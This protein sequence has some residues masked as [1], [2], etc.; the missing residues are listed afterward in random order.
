MVERPMPQDVMKFKA[1][2][3]GN[4][5]AR[6]VVWGMLGVAA[7][8]GCFFGFGDKIGANT[9]QMK[10]I[11]CAIPSIPFFLIGFMPIMGMPMEK[12]LIPIIVDNFIAPAIRKKEI[13]NPEYE[14]Y[15]KSHYGEYEFSKIEESAE[16]AKGSAKKTTKSANKA[17]SKVDKKKSYTNS[18]G[19]YV[20]KKS[21]KYPG[22]K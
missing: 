12:V 17:K 11:I 19:Q 18:S 1:K 14:K 15:M 21:K 20:C 13:H 6:Q 9:T 16:T 3:M 22:I 7:C 5:T 2:L 10:I 4:F 8:V